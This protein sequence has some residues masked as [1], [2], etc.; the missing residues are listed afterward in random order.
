MADPTIEPTE[1][2]KDD[3]LGQ[4]DMVWDPKKGGYVKKTISAGLY[5]KM[6]A[7]DNKQ[8]AVAAGAGAAGELAQFF[9]GLTTLNDPSVKAALRDKARLAAQIRKG[10]DLLTRGEKA[11]YLDAG[12]APAERAAERAEDT[13]L[14]VAASTG[15]TGARNFMAAT[16][17]SRKD[18]SDATLALKADIAGEDVRRGE[19][20]KVSDEKARAGM[21]EV[22]AMMFD[23]R[24][25]HLTEPIHRFLGS[26]AKGVGV[27]LANQPGESFA[28]E[29]NAARE[30]ELTSEQIERLLELSEGPFARRRVK[31]YMKEMGVSMPAKASGGSPEIDGEG[32]KSSVRKG[33][34][35]AKEAA[36]MTRDLSVGKGPVGTGTSEQGKSINEMTDAEAKAKALA[37]SGPESEP[38]KWKKEADLKKT[39][40][41]RLAPYSK[42]D[43][44]PRVHGLRVAQAWNKGDYTY[45]YDREKNVW[46]TYKD[47]K[48]LDFEVTIDEAEASDD[49]NVREL[50]DLAL[51]EGLL[52][53]R[54]LS[55]GMV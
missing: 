3:T 23:I 36:R 19:V 26:V 10:P 45:V 28:A 20:K 5:K 15:N 37:T 55:A 30:A 43:M 1:E 53:D 22:D 34:R 31:N 52:I 21:D 51:R 7:A 27:I 39:R 18:I 42:S 40:Q 48:K 12:L 8:L 44:D 11:D 32:T 47:N 6:Q 17:G 46:T 49:P 14:K 35:E 50:Y 29:V 9:V 24:K 13:A 16:Q 2:P 4:D 38:D 25:T 33:L 41:A 54:E